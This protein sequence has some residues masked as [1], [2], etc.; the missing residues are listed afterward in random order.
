MTPEMT[1]S[2]V[3]I[4]CP[5]PIVYMPGRA[6]IA[7]NAIGMVVTVPAVRIVGMPFTKTTAAG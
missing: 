1:M 4:M 7:E 5:D 6:A 2:L 3:V